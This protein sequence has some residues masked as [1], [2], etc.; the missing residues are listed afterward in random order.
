MSKR[1]IGPFELESELGA[2]G[3]GIVYL[4]TYPKTGQKVALK[5]L[6]PEM[7]ADKRVFKRFSQE[8]EIL[9]KL[10]HPHIVRYY[11]SGKTG[12]QQYYAMEVLKGGSISNLIKKRGRLSW[13]QTLDFSRQICQALTHA[14]EYGIIHRDLKPANLFLSK[15]EQLKLGDFGIARDMQSTGITAAGR[16]VGT[17]AY[18][19]PEQIAGKPAI[20]HK[21][22]LYALGCVMFEMLTGRTPFVTENV[23]QMMMKQMQEL[24]PRVTEFSQDC[25]VWVEAVIL[26]LLEKKPED[27]YFDALAVEMALNDVEQKISRNASIV[28]ETVAHGQTIANT[29]KDQ[30]SL[31]RILK[32]K[33]KKKK[34]KKVPLYEKA[35]F[36]TLL[37]LVL[38]AGVTWGMWPI[39]EQKMYSLAKELMAT[40]N[41]QGQW[42]VAR[43]K[44]LDPYL[45]R[46]PEGQHVAW[47]N[48]QIDKIEIDITERRIKRSAK[49]N[50]DPKS[51]AEAIA[52]QAYKAERDSDRIQALAQYRSLTVLFGDNEEARYYVII[53]KRKIREILDPSQNNKMLGLIDENLLKAERLF[54]SGEEIKAESIWKA[55]VD[56]FGENQEFRQQVEY[57]QARQA[58]KKPEELPYK[59]G[60]NDENPQ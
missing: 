1:K 54:R 24:P 30:P 5:V 37:L 4:A 48:E 27:R 17:Y 14:H 40:E 52:V 38:V 7:C 18:M 57:A 29:L 49:L 19:A 15:N 60:S 35:W 9:K 22:D 59:P 51:E 16:T 50:R 33:R 13:E 28:R 26:Q 41:E 32:S 12:S 58:G 10:K 56:A 20:S 53:A 43:D 34:K 23:P 2:G 25:P 55:V 46:F 11:G 39:G 8:V 44:Y 6:A 47:V 45:E 42:G 36:L 31:Q 3:M 21:T